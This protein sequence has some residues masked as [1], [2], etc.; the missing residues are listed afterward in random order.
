MDALDRAIS[1]AEAS[2]DEIID[3]LKIREDFTSFFVGRSRELYA[4]SQFG[5]YPGIKS[6]FERSMSRKSAAPD[7]AYRG[8]FVEVN[9]TFERGVKSIA[10]AVLLDRQS[11]V[12]RFSDLDTDFRNRHSVFSAKVLAKLHDNSIH[13]AKYDFATL[14]RN[15]GSCLTDAEPV[16]LNTDVFT[17]FIGNC[18]PERL[19]SLFQNLGLPPPFDEDL[20]KTPALK[21]WS[22]KGGAK[23]AATAAQTALEEQI[24]RRNDIVHGV[25][26]GQRIE[27]NELERAAE[28]TVAL[29]QGFSAKARTT[30][31]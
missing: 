29:L 11:K 6:Q 9:S 19:E 3:N 18:T 2:I 10:E 7:A 22:G 5:N 27:A 13:G 1:T 30:M 28:L 24:E 16:R 4:Y 23:E 31:A 17:I 15:L 25:I 20:G 21:K 14:Q 26:G 12:R 8:L